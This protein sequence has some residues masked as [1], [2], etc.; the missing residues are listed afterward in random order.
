LP[1][2]ARHGVAGIELLAAGGHLE[3]ADQMAEPKRPARVAVDI[4]GTFTDLVHLDADGGIGLQKTLTTPGRFEEAVMSTFTDARLDEVGRVAFLA[5]GTTVVI[6]ALTERTGAPTALL[7]TRG[8][9]DVLEIGR[10]NRPDLYN[11]LYRK[12]VPFVPRWLRLEVTERVSYQGA[13]LT[14]LDEDDVRRAVA[15]A[16]AGGVEAVAICFL[17]SYANPAHERRAAELV[18]ELWAE[19]AV[20]VSSELTN[21]WREYQR[22]S[23]V[24]LDACVKPVAATYLTNLARLL[25][26]AG[27]TP[28]ARH[29][30]QSNGGVSRF[31][32]AAR[33]PL[34]LVESGPVGGV[35]GAAELGK[36][37]G[38]RNIL[39]LDMGGTT[40]KSSLV[41]D[42]V[43]TVSSDYHIQRG[44]RF[45]GYPI[46]L[47]V[48]DI[49]EIGAGGGSIAWF[50]PAGALKV[51]PRSA[52]A[53]PGPAC[54]GRGG[55]RPTVTDANLIAGRLDP[56]YFLGGRLRL[57]AT[58]ARTALR[59]VAGAT[60]V[61]VEQAALGVIRIANANL[62][63]L[64][65]Q[66]SV[67]RG[68]DIREFAVVA[69]G[70]GGPMHATAL[71]RELGARRVIVPVAPGHF[72]AWGMLAADLRHDLVQTHVARVDHADLAEL[73]AVWEKLEADMTATFADEGVPP[74]AVT[75]ARGADMR[76][77][78]QEH[79]VNVPIPGGVFLDTAR[80]DIHEAF[81]AAHERLYTF[82]LHGT[83]AEIVNCRLTG[84]GTVDKPGQAQLGAAD[85]A[86]AR[87]GRREVH[88]DELGLHPAAVYERGHLG[89]GTSLHGPAVIEEP[90][91]TTVVFPDQSVRVDE[92]GNLIVERAVAR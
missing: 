86:A 37:I 49:V 21:E 62:S 5:H 35:I 64:L 9:K 51:G 75:F 31:E 76:Y 33:A 46:K 24:V 22:T 44:P 56:D 15:A 26:D 39:T 6:N 78:G 88:F 8:F 81:A 50:D 89:A 48:V 36:A 55:M 27:V 11:L 13:V 3:E 91:A 40:A 77:A 7:T 4:G 20:S 23:T 34:N 69:F 67:R 1:A 18:R 12:P 83:P 84:H 19:A 25:D 29:A 53:E 10:A 30:M 17:H 57:D 82:R 2:V 42:G 65:R 59:P 79:T 74:A 54:Y 87:K 85:L 80:D 70:G 61:D 28:R 52:G 16:R 72:S 63:Q 68:R 14:P 32:V 38:E 41:E 66:L 92:V 60:G 58:A 90:A 47:P 73:A 43:V 71:A 45:A